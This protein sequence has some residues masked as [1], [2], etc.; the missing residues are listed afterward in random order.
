VEGAGAKARAK[1]VSMYDTEGHDRWYKSREEM[2]MELEVDRA[3]ETLSPSGA[4]SLDPIVVI[5]V[6]SASSPM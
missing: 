4:S 6:A 2:E 3:D 5:A 1:A